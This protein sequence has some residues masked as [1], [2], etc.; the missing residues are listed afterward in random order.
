MFG[1]ID[2]QSEP[3]EELNTREAKD[4][5]AHPLCDP[6]YQP[7]NE[8]GG[9]HA[10]LAIRG[11]QNGDDD[12]L[13]DSP[14]P[15]DLAQHE[16]PRTEQIDVHQAK[17]P[18]A[19]RADALMAF[20]QSTRRREA[21]PPA[22]ANTPVP[23]SQPAVTIASQRRQP[24]DASQT[25]G[26]AH[27]YNRD[28]QERIARAKKASPQLSKMITLR[29]IWALPKGPDGLRP[30]HALGHSAARKNATAGPF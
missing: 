2:D 29:Q 9:G 13:F 5:N 24:P 7:I 16:P 21:S 6:A 30:T 15:G 22:A 27:K 26:P 17:G 19:A 25:G 11:T 4:D 12:D 1:V 18:D 20:L 23:V 3:V 28:F 14:K 8:V 10:V